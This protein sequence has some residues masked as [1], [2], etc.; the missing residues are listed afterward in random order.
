[1]VADQA[2][3][4]RL[5]DGNLGGS[6]DPSRYFNGRFMGEDGLPRSIHDWDPNTPS[7][8]AVYDRPIRY[9]REGRITAT[10]EVLLP[11][12]P[13]KDAKWLRK[14]FLRRRYVHP[15]ATGVDV[16]PRF[17]AGQEQRVKPKL[18]TMAEREARLQEQRLRA[19]IEREQFEAI[20]GKDTSDADEPVEIEVPE[21][22]E[23]AVPDEVAKLRALL[24]QAERE[25]EVA[26]KTLQDVLAKGID[27]AI[28]SN[29][30]HQ[31]NT[32]PV[33]I[34]LETAP[35]TRRKKNDEVTE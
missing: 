30:I 23:L 6:G 10:T 7:I 17:N 28:E 5:T 34:D 12:T 21:G 16:L 15:K 29:P 22:M 26:R 31:P 19:K 14:G 24:E 27:A 8:K 2:I 3:G 4:R 13:N 18:E 11:S 9:D 35:V 32:P 20:H 33:E 25:K 1:M